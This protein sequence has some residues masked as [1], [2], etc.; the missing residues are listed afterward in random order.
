MTFDREDQEETQRAIKEMLRQF[1]E[2]CLN[3][4][5]KQGDVSGQSAEAPPPGKPAAEET[6]S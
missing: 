3:G 5:T 4:T 2:D 6:G 1:S